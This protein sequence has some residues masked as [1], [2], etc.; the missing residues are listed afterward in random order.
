MQEKGMMDEWMI[1]REFMGFDGN[2]NYWARD[3]AYAYFKGA[4]M[5]IIK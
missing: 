4:D 2:P 5:P 3:Y 1:T